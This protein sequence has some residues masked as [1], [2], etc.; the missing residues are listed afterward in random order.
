MNM[1]VLFCIAIMGSSLA[2]YDIAKWR[3]FDEYNATALAL[4]PVITGAL[5]LLIVF[6]TRDKKVRTS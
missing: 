4:L 2:V 1:Q 5:G 3:G 6:V